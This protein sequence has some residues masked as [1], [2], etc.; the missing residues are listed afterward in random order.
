MR[1]GER[2]ICSESGFSPEQQVGLVLLF[3]VLGCR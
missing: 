1:V 3:R 2:G